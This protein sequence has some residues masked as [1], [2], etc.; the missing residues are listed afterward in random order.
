MFLL[1]SRALDAPNEHFVGQYDAAPIPRKKRPIFGAHCFGA[2]CSTDVYIKPMVEFMHQKWHLVFVL[3]ILMLLLTKKLNTMKMASF[4]AAGNGSVQRHCVFCVF[5]CT[6]FCIFTCINPWWNYGRQSAVWMDG[7]ITTC[8][9]RQFSRRC[10]TPS[11]LS[12]GWPLPTFLSLAF[13]VV[14]LYL[15]LWLYLYLFLHLQTYI[16]DRFLAL[17]GHSLPLL[18]LCHR[19]GACWHSKGL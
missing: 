4:G 10:T 5:F 3:I 16:C 7:T 14:F 9:R 12:P 6:C 8:L 19:G 2:R 13:P 15:E 1:G 18:P 17:Y 11:F